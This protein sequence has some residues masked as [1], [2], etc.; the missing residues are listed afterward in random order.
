ME[1]RKCGEEDVVRTGIFYDRTVLRL[2]RGRINYP[3]WIWRVYPSG[4]FVEAMVADRCQ[5][6]CERER[7]IAAAFV[8]NTDPLGD[9]RKG[10]WHMDLPNGAYMVVHALAVSPEFQRT[11]IGS[12]ILRFCAETARAEGYSALR[13]DVVP[14]N[15]PARKL[16][17]KN[18]FLYA[19]DADLDRRIAD[20]PLFSLYELNW[21]PSYTESNLPG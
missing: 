8:L 1:I 21:Q 16:F 19:G 11:G 20:I 9:Y 3:R 4:S 6:I 2:I 14:A 5:Y 10:R 13:A 15:F 7:K 18:G 17:E 12:A